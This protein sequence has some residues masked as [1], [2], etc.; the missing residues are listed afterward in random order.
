MPNNWKSAF[1]FTPYIVFSSAAFLDVMPIALLVRSIGMFIS[2]CDAGMNHSCE[3]RDLV[4]GH[5][6]ILS[7]L[8]NAIPL[9]EV[10]SHK[11]A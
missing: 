1:I 4:H 5:L 2:V 9:S 7:F 8:L 3:C 6:S 11:D 10:S